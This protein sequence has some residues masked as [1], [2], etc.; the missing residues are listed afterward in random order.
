MKI[1][2]I[3]ILKCLSQKRRHAETQSSKQI[4][5]EETKPKLKKKKPFKKSEKK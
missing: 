1:W 4:S 5:Q 3:K 2:Y